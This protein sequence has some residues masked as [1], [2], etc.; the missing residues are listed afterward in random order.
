MK[1][2]FGICTTSG[3]EERV[4]KI[5]ASIKENNIPY[6]DYEVIVVGGNYEN[7]DSKNNILAVPFDESV[8][9]GW[10]TRKKNIITQKA[11][12]ENIVYMHDYIVLEQGWYEAMKEYGED[13]QV[14]MTR[15]N[16]YDNS[17][18]RD[19]TLCG[20]WKNNIFVE[21]D[22]CRNLLP[23]SERRLTGW[24]YI[25]GAYWIAKKSFMLENPLNETLC[26]RQGEDVEWSFRVKEKTVF[27]L[28]EN[29]TARVSKSN[30][31]A[32]FDLA[33]QQYLNKIYNLLLARSESLPSMKNNLAR[34]KYL[35]E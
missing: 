33:N 9:D 18:Y 13:W 3:N 21:E 22:T 2:T 26:W 34:E 27:K 25:S 15:I 8:R 4:S 30:K 29:A 28:N 11:K 19:W 12:F 20:G 6:A 23:Y 24:M 10:I 35:N 5:I 17:R 14:L 7:S 31:S 1:F 32:F 16:N